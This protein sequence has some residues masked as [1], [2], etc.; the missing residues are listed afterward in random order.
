MALILVWGRPL[1]LG[2][3]IN[4][5]KLKLKF[6]GSLDTNPKTAASHTVAHETKNLY[7]D[8][9]LCAMLARSVN[10]K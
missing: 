7:D 5:T 6:L 4:K 10:L 9:V 8:D 3:Y 2:S 1:P